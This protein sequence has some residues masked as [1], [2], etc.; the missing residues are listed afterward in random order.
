[1]NKE[2]ERANNAE[3][4]LSTA[5][6]ELHRLTVTT[7]AEKREVKVQAREAA[8]LMEKKR[9]EEFRVALNEKE[10]TIQSLI[11]KADTLACDFQKRS[12]SA[13]DANRKLLK[14][15]YDADTKIEHM[16][17][18]FEGKEKELDCLVK[19]IETLR[20]KLKTSEGMNNC[21]FQFFHRI[22]FNLFCQDEKRKLERK[23]H[24]SEL[25]IASLEKGNE[26][27]EEMINKAEALRRAAESAVTLEKDTLAIHK[28]QLEQVC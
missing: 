11:Q 22:H 24:Q 7:E 6:D 13:E 5:K 27:Q 4:S 18:S 20:S 12:D 21:R 9:S 23:F 1:M 15:K 3:L 16:Q 2:M 26:G 19:D 10:E 25:R 28:T 17:Y 8:Q 14:E